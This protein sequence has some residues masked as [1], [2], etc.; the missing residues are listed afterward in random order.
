MVGK[1]LI[2]CVKKR[3][4][5]RSRRID[6]FKPLVNSG[7]AEPELAFVQAYVPVPTPSPSLALAPKIKILHPDAIGRVRRRAQH[8]VQLVTQALAGSLVDV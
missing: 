2:R 5:K 8:C 3:P 7:R 4:L 6:P 1:V